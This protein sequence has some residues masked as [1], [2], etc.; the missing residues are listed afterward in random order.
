MHI[1]IQ[2]SKRKGITEENASFLSECLSLG[3][4][5]SPGSMVGRGKRAQCLAMKTGCIKKTTGRVRLQYNKG[6]KNKN[7]TDTHKV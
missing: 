1:A 4:S 5:K 3:V 7:S 6:I 2:G